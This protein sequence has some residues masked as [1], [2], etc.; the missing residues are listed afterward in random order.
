MTEQE[1][2]AGRRHI[3]SNSSNSTTTIIPIHTEFAEQEILRRTS[4]RS[5][6]ED[7]YDE[8]LFLSRL[9][10]TSAARTEIVN[11]TVE[12][13]IQPIIGGR[14]AGQVEA[15]RDHLEQIV[16]NIGRSLLCNNWLVVPTDN[17]AYTKDRGYMS[18]HRFSHAVIKDILNYLNESKLVTYKEGK[19]FN[20]GGKATRIFPSAEFQTELATLALHTEQEFNGQYLSFSDKNSPYKEI[21]KELGADHPDIR[22]MALINEFL[23]DQHWALKGPV[24]LRYKSDPFSGGRLYTPYQN[25]PSRNYNIRKATL[26]NGHT[27]SEVDYSANHLRLNLAV[28]A[29]QDAGDTPYEDI[30]EKAGPPFD[31]GM[32]KAYVT[33]SMGSSDR[34]RAYGAMRKLGMDM[35]QFEKLE[36]AT[37]ARYPKL[38]LYT[39]FGVNAQSIEGAILRDVMLAGIDQGITTL[40]V[41]DALA[42]Q[43]RDANWAEIAML[44]Y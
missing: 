21:V 6:P 29:S 26:L 19:A 9:T 34:Q 32:V 2:S 13:L 14:R 10:C 33:R 44:E 28:L 1:D 43:E 15:L 37:L 4:D 23:Q 38:S 12:R 41:H 39:G 30:M 16:L 27:I 22:D 8:H 35:R 17:R 5:L 36:Q 7:E 25:L 20:N 31:R 11:A 18:Q 42:V 3:S 24:T 40:P